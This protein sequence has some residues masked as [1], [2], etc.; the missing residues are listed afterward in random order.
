MTGLS[1]RKLQTETVERIETSDRP[2]SRR[3]EISFPAELAALHAALARLTRKGYIPG[4][5][6]AELSTTGLWTP[7]PRGE[8]TPAEPGPR[9]RLAWTETPGPRLRPPA[10]RDE[11]TESWE[12]TGAT[13]HAMRRTAAMA[14][15]ANRGPNAE[16]QLDWRQ[17]R[18]S[19]NTSANIRTTLDT[20]ALESG[21]LVVRLQASLVK[22]IA[23]TFRVGC[24]ATWLYDT[25]RLKLSERDGRRAVTV[26]IRLA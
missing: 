23:D 12:L 11:R 9:L 7:I 13:V 22:A 2:P 26:P 20:P 16:C 8:S 15:S 5:D 1:G 25:N 17:R 24:T 4:R 3:E 6:P 19:A 18:L 14:I 10:V 21:N